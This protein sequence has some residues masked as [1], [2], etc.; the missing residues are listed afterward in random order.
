MRREWSFLR[1]YIGRLGSWSAASK[2]L[3]RVAQ[4]HPE[5]FSHCR[6]EALRSPSRSMPPIK[7][8]ETSLQSVLQW[9]LPLFNSAHIEEV[10]QSIS[11]TEAQDLA[12]LFYKRYRRSIQ[13]SVHAEVLMMEHFQHRGLQFMD[14]DRYIGCSK[15]SCYFC[16]LYMKCHPKA[17]VTRPCHGNVWIRWCTTHEQGPHTVRILK[18]M[19]MQI[20]QEIQSRILSHDPRRTQNPDSTTGISTSIP[21][22]PFRRVL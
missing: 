17:F 15:P 12:T 14:D 21:S 1:H 3:V 8:A 18:N 20:Q 11:G 5:I 16:S 7:D 10:L 13:P 6:V 4:N 9:M 2:V 22:A 19:T